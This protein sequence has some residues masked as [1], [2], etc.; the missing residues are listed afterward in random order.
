VLRRFVGD[1]ADCIA[2][3]WRTTQ[4]EYTWRRSLMGLYAPFSTCTAQALDFAARSLGHHF[5]PDA[6]TILLQ[7]YRELPAFPDAANGLARMRAAGHRMVA[8]SNGEVAFV[9][10]V[11]THAGILPML[12]DVVS[13]DEVK[14]YKPAAAVYRH[15]AARMGTAESA[16]DTGPLG[17][18]AGPH[19]RGPGRTQR[20]SRSGGMKFC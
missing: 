15:L 6:M 8:F 3:L 5:A 10:A 2:L 7:A 12:A 17:D 11:L 19:R 9:R 1:D 13:V 16:R 4:L 14:T 20:A 18:R